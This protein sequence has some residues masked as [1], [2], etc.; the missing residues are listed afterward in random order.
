MEFFPKFEDWKKEYLTQGDTPFFHAKSEFLVYV[1][2]ESYKFEDEH[3]KEF[4][5]N[6]E[7]IQ[8]VS[9]V[10]IG[11][12]E[13]D[14]IEIYKDLQE[15]WATDKVI[16]VWEGDNVGQK[17]SFEYIKNVCYYVA[18]LAHPESNLTKE[19]PIKRRSEIQEIL[20]NHIKKINC[21]RSMLKNINEAINSGYKMADVLEAMREIEEDTAKIMGLTVPQ[22]YKW[23][24]KNTK[25]VK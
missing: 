8:N 7:Y 24:E 12:S 10:I 18:F 1:E 22:L 16:D 13:N 2:Q 25:E 17:N 5:L 3:E 6:C 15:D 14:L 11:Y 23:I 20:I 19:M 9:G 4:L 21:S